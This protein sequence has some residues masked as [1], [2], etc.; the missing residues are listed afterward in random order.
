MNDHDRPPVLAHQQFRARSSILDGLSLPERF[1]SIHA[2]NLWGAKTSKSGLGSEAGAT[3]TLRSELRPMLDALHVRSL[4]DAPCGDASWIVDANLSGINYTG[5]DI[6]EQLIDQNVA[7]RGEFGTFCVADITRDPLPLADAILCRDSL[8]HLSFANIGRAI[9]NFKST[10]AQWLI[11][12]SFPEW[13]QNIDCEDG[14]W[15]ALNLERAP[16]NWP[17][18]AMLLNEQCEEAGGGWRDKSLGVWR[19]SDLD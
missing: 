17:P 14:D 5:I 16:F 15:R 9:R 19:L 12:T 8:V 6:V 18:P 11:T 3:E 4:L 13:R 1:T 10:H 7:E 2:S